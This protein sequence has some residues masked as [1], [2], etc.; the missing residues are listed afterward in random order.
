MKSLRPAQALCPKG[1]HVPPDTWLLREATMCKTERREQLY[2][3]ASLYNQPP[4]LPC[5]AGRS[6]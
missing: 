2:H 4:Q 6:A 1:A 5:L 3:L